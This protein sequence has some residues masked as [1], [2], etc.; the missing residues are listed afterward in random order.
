MTEKTDYSIQTNDQNLNEKAKQL[1]CNNMKTPLGSGGVQFTPDQA[2]ASLISRKLAA[3]RTELKK[4]NSQN[5]E[6]EITFV[7]Q[8]DIELGRD[9]SVLDKFI[10]DIVAD[11]TSV[12][13]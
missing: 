9:T 13:V 8:E 6:G 2:D 10:E 3:V 7:T 5:S 1:Y 11:F 12:I 4:H